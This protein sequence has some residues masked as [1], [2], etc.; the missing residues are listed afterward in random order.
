MSRIHFG[1]L[2]SIPIRRNLGQLV[3]RR[4]LES[5]LSLRRMAVALGYRNVNKGIR[6]V[7]SLEVSGVADETFWRKVQNVLELDKSEVRQAF[8]RDW[9]AY[10]T[11]LDESIE[12]RCIIR[13]MPAIYSEVVLPA[14]VKG[15][16]EQARKF[17]RNLARPKHRKVWLRLSRRLTV[18][19]DERGED[20]DRLEAIPERPE[21]PSMRVSG[22]RFLLRD[23]RCSK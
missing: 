1:N 9:Q 15:D 12:I 3:R 8:E 14:D 4:R 23:K 16:P 20:F 13:W 2:P 6:R 17:A 19:V 5:C 10:Q 21:G 18:W 11:W 7:Q 22:R